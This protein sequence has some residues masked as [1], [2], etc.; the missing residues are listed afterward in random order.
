MLIHPRIPYRTRSSR[1]SAL[2]LL[3]Y[4]L[5]AAHQTLPPAAVLPEQFSSPAKP[6]RARG[7]V[8]LMHAVLED[9]VHCFQNLS[10]APGKRSQRLAKEAES[11]FFSDDTR[12]PFSFVN[13]CAVLG[14]DPEYIRLGLQRWRQQCLTTPHL[15]KVRR[16]SFSVHRPLK[17]AA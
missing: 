10:G 6:S 9:A 15:Q 17:I 12:W 16:R 3:L 11:W 4:D 1:R 8:A 14:L 7:E 2:P 13:I 5:S